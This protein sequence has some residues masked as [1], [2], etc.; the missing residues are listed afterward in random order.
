MVSSLFNAMFE[1][2]ID[3]LTPAERVQL[4]EETFAKLIRICHDVAG[5]DSH[6]VPVP[7][8][9]VLVKAWIVCVGDWVWLPDCHFGEVAEIISD[10][11]D[12]K[13]VLVDGFVVYADRQQNIKIAESSREAVDWN[14]R[15]HT[16]NTSTRRRIVDAYG[17]KSAAL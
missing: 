6:S 8:V 13:I 7:P 3:E 17:F 4:S 16:L 12:V 11:D 9:S 1:A 10:C 5:G 14:T 2:A 15:W